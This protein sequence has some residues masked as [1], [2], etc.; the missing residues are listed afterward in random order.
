MEGLD[1]VV[2]RVGA[3]RDVALIRARGYLDTQTCGAMRV[4][5]AE[6]MQEG[7]LQ[8][9]VDMGQVNYVSSAGWGVFVGEIKAIR[10]SGGDL[11]I[12]QMLPEVYDIFEM[13]EFNRILD[14]YDCIEEAIDD[15][16]LSIGL[17]ITKSLARSVQPANSDITVAAAAPT[18]QMRNRE[19]GQKRAK[20]RASYSKPQIDEKLIPL[21]E[22]I[23]AIIID[24]PYQSAWSIKKQLYSERFGYT[25]VSLFRVMKLLKKM[26][27]DSKEKRYRFY[28]SR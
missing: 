5:I 10:D 8:M 1:I 15:F 16:D 24:D 6:I 21:T 25:K 26:N 13:L 11:K 18:P 4:K 20:G 17:D 9:I 28:R 22:K 12:V 23:K 27:L 19:A 2:G 3:R 7:F 14:C